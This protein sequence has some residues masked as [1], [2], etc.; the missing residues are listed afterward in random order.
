MRSGRPQIGVPT[1]QPDS[2]A[3][4]LITLESLWQ[5]VA[6]EVAPDSDVRTVITTSELDYLEEVPSLLAEAKRSRD[7]ATL[8]LV[9]V[10][11]RHRGGAMANAAL[12]YRVRGGAAEDRERE[13]PPAGTARQGGEPVTLRPY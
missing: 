1:S 10:V 8:D 6:R 7:D 4:A 9:E 11:K 13:D 2:G 12:A 5:E 3:S